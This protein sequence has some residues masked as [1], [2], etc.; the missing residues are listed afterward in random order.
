MKNI[1]LFYNDIQK[2]PPILT[3][4]DCL[5]QNG[6]EVLLLGYCSCEKTI[7]DFEIKG[8]VYRELVVDCVSSFPVVK[9]VRIL[10]Y[11]KRVY[12]IVNKFKEDDV[13][14]WV[15]GERN[16]WVLHGLLKK[17]KSILYLFEIP[18]LK[19]NARFRF[20]SPCINQFKMMSSASKIVCCEYN[21]AKITESFFHLKET[22]TII[23]NKPIVELMEIPC[24]STVVPELFELCL[25]NKI[26]LYQGIFNY[27]ERRLDEICKAIDLLPSNYHLLLM[28]PND[29]NKRRLEEK[30]HSNKV[31]FVPFM[32]FPLHLSVTRLA[33]IGVLSYFSSSGNIESTLNTLYCA[34]NKIHEYS[35]F[36]VPSISNDLPAMKEIYSKYSI[37][38]IVDYDSNQIAEAILH[39]SDNYGD[40]TGFD[41][42]L[43]QTDPERM[44]LSL[45]DKE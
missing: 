28:G 29:S 37:G 27:P 34:P 16:A 35:L 5:L 40:Y 6:E 14:L 25:K 32:P 7:L 36:N 43:S 9:L 20:I 11:K 1:I 8:L 22:P 17:Y 38:E 4:I 33:H 23:P 41:A 18:R 45:I 3:T 10:K 44:I 24:L 31:H 39:I 12:N 21:R 13:V 2:Y 19:I 26:I 15:F 30:Y 42:F